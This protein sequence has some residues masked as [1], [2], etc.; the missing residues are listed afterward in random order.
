M[1][2]INCGT[3]NDDN[4]WK[5]VQCGNVLY[6]RQAAVPSFAGREAQQTIVIPDYLIPA[7]LCTVFCCMPLGIPAIVFAAQV[8]TYKAN[9]KIKEALEAS[10]KGEEV[11]RFFLLCPARLHRY[12]FR[13]LDFDVR[14]RNCGEIQMMKKKYCQ[15]FAEKPRH[16]LVHFIPVLPALFFLFSYKSLP[17]LFLPVLFLP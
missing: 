16:F 4:A 3:Q 14:V 6:R 7:I 17:F 13:N 1:Y 5:C 12:L 15:E 8:Q 9:G 11:H 10:K 2:C